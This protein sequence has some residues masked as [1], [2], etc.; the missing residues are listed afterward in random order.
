MKIFKT[1]AAFF[2]MILTGLQFQ[3][4]SQE[5]DI[6]S[7]KQ[8]V[9]NSITRMHKIFG[10]DEN[11][12]YLIQYSG[13]QYYLQKLD[14]NLNLI[15]EEPIK[16][17][18]GL[19]TY[20]LESVVDFYD[21]IYIF[22]SRARIN[23]ITLY[24]QKLDKDNLQ[25]L[26]DPV[27]ITTIKTIKGAWADFN[28]ALSRNETKLVVF[29][30]TKLVW[31]GAQFNEIYVFG[32]GLSLVWKRN[33][34]F[35]FKGQGPRDNHY[36]VDEI[37]NVSILSLL[38]R[39]SIISLIRSFRNLYTIYRYTD[40]GKSTDEYPVTLDDLYI[41][42]IKIIAGED[43]GLVCAGLYSELF[44]TGI[45]GTFY[46]KVDG[47]TAQIT[48]HH[49]N[50]FDEAVLA[51]LANM[52]EPMIKD[53]ELINYVI[54]DIV[55]RERGKT[56]LISEQVFRQTYNT[57]NNLIVSCF[58][59][60]GQ[61]FWTRIIPK[62]QNFNYVN[63]PNTASNLS[64]IYGY[65][66]PGT[67]QTFETMDNG[68]YY[69]TG[70]LG[71]DGIGLAGY[72]AYIR[73]SGFINPDINNYCSYALIAP[74]EKSGIVLVFNDNIGNQ[75]ASNEYR[76]LNRPKKS[77]LLAISID[78]FGNL[79]RIPLTAWKKKALFPEPMRFYDTRYN[80]IVIPAFRNRSINF[81]KLT[82]DA[83]P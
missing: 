63:I 23:D 18:K 2:V 35:E 72:R 52:K 43:G 71:P 57:Y 6:T 8:D 82:A 9:L 38:K 3:A 68:Q 15:L 77:Y 28:F 44:N 75:N 12:F 49:L 45:R 22:V 42:G 39:E 83:I 69:N 64:D 66:S 61:I 50:A 60:D 36:V 74:V 40:D 81:Y 10:H 24:Y 62:K 13:T 33:D 30:R 78:E 54:T 76:A 27:E 19:R 56:I 65:T 80:T 32:E 37:G 14:N 70:S 4:L 20:R 7:S 16:L 41:R 55:S 26:S 73:E 53:E 51:E 17:F 25:P 48:D 59:S 79:K 31:S 47:I 5:I 1:I 21:D 34:S 46:F 29:C 11:N 67:E 58:D